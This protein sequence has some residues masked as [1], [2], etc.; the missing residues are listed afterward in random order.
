MRFLKDDVVAISLGFLWRRSHPTLTGAG[1][2]SMALENCK[3]TFMNGRDIG[4]AWIAACFGEGGWPDPT[5][6]PLPAGCLAAVRIF[7]SA[8]VITCDKTGL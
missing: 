1:I 3:I 7:S 5:L 4:S 2:L 8:L 6:P